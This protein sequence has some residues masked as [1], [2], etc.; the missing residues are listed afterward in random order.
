MGHWSFIVFHLLSLVFCIFATR[1]TFRYLSKHQI[2]AKTRYLLFGFIRTRY[3]GLFYI[4]SISAL[5]LAS[6]I[7]DTYYHW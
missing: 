4:M 6:L 5:T 7:F 1:V 2:S 3:I